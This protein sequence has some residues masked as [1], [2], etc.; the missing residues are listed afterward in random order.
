RGV[1]PG[2][3]PTHHSRSKRYA[4]ER[5]ALVA[6]KQ[7]GFMAAA[8]ATRAGAGARRVSRD[9][10]CRFGGEIFQSQRRRNGLRTGS[11]QINLE[12]GIGMREPG[13]RNQEP[14]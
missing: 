11:R 10:P 6:T 1:H 2:V 5:R 7:A 12:S 3:A 14:G 4:T 9:T 13:T 8:A